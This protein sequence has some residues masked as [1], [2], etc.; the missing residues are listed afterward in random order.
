MGKKRGMLAPKQH[1]HHWAIPQNGWGKNVPD[2]IKNQPWNIKP[3]P[4]AEVHGR[5]AYLA[6]DL[7]E[8]VLLGAQPRSVSLAA[9]TALPLPLDWSEQRR[10]FAAIG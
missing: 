6:P 1:G 7:T 4:S 3:M 10:R 8:A 9:L 2:R 5:L